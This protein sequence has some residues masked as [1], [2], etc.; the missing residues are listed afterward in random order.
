MLLLLI[1]WMKMLRLNLLNLIMEYTQQNVPTNTKNIEIDLPAIEDKLTIS[2]NE[3]QSCLEEI[4]W[5]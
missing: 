3:F 5:Q 4:N 1:I 2:V